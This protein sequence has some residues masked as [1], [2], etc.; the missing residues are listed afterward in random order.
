MEIK[1]WGFDNDRVQ[2]KSAQEMKLKLYPRV[3][4]HTS[5]AE[6]KYRSSSINTNSGT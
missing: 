1:A 4:I 3:N 5:L 6:E 2:Y